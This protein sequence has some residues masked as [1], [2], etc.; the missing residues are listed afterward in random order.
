MVHRVE[1]IADLQDALERPEYKDGKYW[2]EVKKRCLAFCKIM[3]EV[4][5]HSVMDERWE[6]LKEEANEKCRDVEALGEDTDNDA[7]RGEERDAETG[8][9]CRVGRKGTKG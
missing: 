9:W 6:Y 2:V 8:K 5:E 3:G 4:L 1:D 7:E